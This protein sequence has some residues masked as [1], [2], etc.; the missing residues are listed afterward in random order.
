MLLDWELFDQ[1]PHKVDLMRHPDAQNCPAHEAFEDAL[2][3]FLDWE[4]TPQH[5]VRRPFQGDYTQL[6][7]V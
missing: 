1:Y 4:A 6:H 2:K 3:Q 7:Q 5:C